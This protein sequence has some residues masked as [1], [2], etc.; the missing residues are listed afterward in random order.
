VVGQ[1]HIDEVARQHLVLMTPS[2]LEQHLVAAGPTTGGADQPSAPSWNDGSAQSARR[3]DP[4]A[5][6][7]P[8]RCRSSAPRADGPAVAVTP[9]RG[10]RPGPGHTVRGT[11][12][13]RLRAP[14]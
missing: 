6:A 11:P 2:A 13:A 14:R 3:A 12:E 10:T 9:G 4:S 8:R 1:Q 5:R 7:E